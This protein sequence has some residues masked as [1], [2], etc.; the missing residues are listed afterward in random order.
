MALL[1]KQIKCRLTSDTPSCNKQ[2]RT[3][4]LWWLK[5]FHESCSWAYCNSTSA[6]SEKILHVW[7]KEEED[8]MHINSS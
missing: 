8:H 1:K 2:M 6:D 7:V 3:T 5:N 4:K